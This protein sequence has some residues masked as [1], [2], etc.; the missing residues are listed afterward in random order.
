MF[1][2][3]FLGGITLKMIPSEKGSILSTSSSSALP[4]KVIIYNKMSAINTSDQPFYTYLIHFLKLEGNDVEAL[5]ELVESTLHKLV[6]LLLLS[7]ALF[8]DFIEII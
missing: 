7:L 5:Q 3:L 6:L 8:C 1:L 4:P 2:Q